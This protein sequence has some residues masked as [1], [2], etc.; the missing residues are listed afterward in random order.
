MFLS[1]DVK[2]AISS[3]NNDVALSFQHI[4]TLHLTN[5]ECACLAMTRCPFLK[6]LSVRVRTCKRHQIPRWRIHHRYVDASSEAMG[7]LR[8]SPGNFC[9]SSMVRLSICYCYVLLRYAH[10]ISF[11]SPFICIPTKTFIFRDFPLKNKFIIYWHFIGYLLTYTTSCWSLYHSPRTADVCDKPKIPEKHPQRDHP[12]QWGCEGT[13][14]VPGKTQHWFSL[15]NSRSSNSPSFHSLAG[16]LPH[17]QP[18][19]CLWMC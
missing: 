14:R 10:Y 5:K 11:K 9:V 15:D 2:T 3:W 1:K 18:W 4:N 13:A 8:T 19:L 7:N 16:I 17:F 12:H 6:L